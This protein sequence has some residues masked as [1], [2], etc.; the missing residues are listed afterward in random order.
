M[1]SRYDAVVIGA[2]GDDG[3]PAA[4]GLVSLSTAPPATLETLP[5]IGP[6]LAAAIVDHRDRDGPFG[7]VD[8][9]LAVPGIGPAKLDALRELVV[10]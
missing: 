10:P 3:G 5:G 8:D 9:L 7:T 2:G 4:G 6:S 1:S